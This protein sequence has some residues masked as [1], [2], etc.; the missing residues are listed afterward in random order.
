MYVRVCVC[1]CVQ[2]KSAR[3]RSRGGGSL[4]LRKIASIGKKPTAEQSKVV[5]SPDKVVTSPDKSEAP[6]GV[7]GEETADDTE[8]EGGEK[9]H[10]ESQIKEE[11]EASE[12][13]K[14]TEEEEAMDIEECDQADKEGRKGGVV[15]GVIYAHGVFP[16]FT[17]IVLITLSRSLPGT[18]TGSCRVFCF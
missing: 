18:T 9:Q 6:A 4:L 5:T 3:G 16:A 14:Q 12:N 7:G 1:V 10:D 2:V 11:Q 15:V 17:V 8:T 13:D